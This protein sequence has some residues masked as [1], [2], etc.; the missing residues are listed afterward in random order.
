MAKKKTTKK[1]TSTKKVESKKSVK[2]TVKDVAKRTSPRARALFIVV[3]AL[4]VIAIIYSVI[5]LIHRA[6]KTKTIIQFAPNSAVV[7][8]NGTQI[9]NASTS[10]LIPG[11]YHLKVAYD[12]H[13][14]TYEQ[15]IEI[16]ADTVAEYYGI[17]AP[18]DDEG[19]EFVEKHRQEY[20]K[21]EGLVGSLLSR[22]GSKIK[23]QYPILNNIPINNSLYSISYQYDDENKPVVYVKSDPKYLDVAVAKMRLFENV[24]L[25]S[26]NIVF[27]NNNV[28][29]NY[30]QNSIT[31][32][33]KFI[34]AAYELPDNYVVSDPL[35]IDGYTY[36]TVYIDD[37]ENNA[38]YSHYRVILKKN[39]SGEWESV[40]TPQPLF[41][42]NN[43]SN[44]DKKILKTIN[45]Y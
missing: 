12:D 37:Y 14:E 4:F 18:L 3:V 27:L 31:D 42:I 25:E 13:L 32:P 16:A 5:T 6:G 9:P 24:E 35:E 17:L 41:T 38:Q 11:K 23:E 45:S 26:E 22:Q 28:F 30:K 21:V 1:S 10:W 33:Q 36:T 44:L 7:T 29:E 2:E 19:K 8:L 39:D 43:T 34:R 20:V 15:D 40:A